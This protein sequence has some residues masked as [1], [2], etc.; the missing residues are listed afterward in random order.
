MTE[1]PQIF[2][3]EFLLQ[4][5][6]EDQLYNKVSDQFHELTRGFYGAANRELLGH[7]RLNKDARVLELACGTGHLAI[8]IATQVAPGEVVGV[9]ISPQMIAQG[10]EAAQKAE[11]KNVSFVERNIHHILPEFKPGD[12]NVALS[13][14]ALSYLGCDF[15]LKELKGILGENGQ[16]G[17][18]TSSINSLVEWQPLFSE[19]LGGSADSSI[20][21]GENGVPD[22]PLN[23]ADLERRMREAGFKNIKVVSQ[24][25]PLVFENARQAASFLISA[26]WISN[27]FFRVQ[28]KEM[29]RH[30]LEWAIGRVEEHHQDDPHVSTSIEFLI[31]WNEP[32]N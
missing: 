10:R 8:E 30:L 25:I 2:D 5:D 29:R 12:F 20:P 11:L 18:T 7:L 17:I 26:G 23:A 6:D 22:L 31:G 9:D 32:G 14:F 28:D 15:L 13:C 21:L 24:K 19:F 3:L 4:L 1:S 16:V 27:Y